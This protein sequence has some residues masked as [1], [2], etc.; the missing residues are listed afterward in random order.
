MLRL[1]RQC[2]SVRRYPHV[3][4]PGLCIG[5]TAVAMIYGRAQRRAPRLSEGTGHDAP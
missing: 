4:R 2:C 3:F 5:H 1:D